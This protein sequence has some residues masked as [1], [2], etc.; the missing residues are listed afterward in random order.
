MGRVRQRGTAAEL[1]VRAWA[2]AIGLRYT[3]DNSDLPGSPDLA[4]RTRRLAIFVHGCYWHRHSSC[5]NATTPKSN[6]AFWLA[7]FARNRARDRAAVRALQG[8]GF[9]VV[10]IWE[11]EVD[12]TNN[13]LQQLV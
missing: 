1:V 9:R 12:D 3:L 10:V 13:R 2:R 7:K 11:C 5:R 4:N 6:R 8:R